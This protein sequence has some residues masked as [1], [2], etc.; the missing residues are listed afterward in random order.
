MPQYTFI[1][2]ES[3]EEETH[4]FSSWKLKDEFLEENVHL[5]Q[6]LTAPK[7]VGEHG[8]TIVRKTSSDWKDH[9]KMIKK[10]SGRNNTINTL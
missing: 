4:F 6:K 7:I 1:N 8:D 10:G 3:D 2:K 5:K 9:L